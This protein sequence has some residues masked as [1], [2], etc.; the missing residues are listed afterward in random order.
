MTRSRLFKQASQCHLPLGLMRGRVSR[1]PARL[2][3]P[4]PQGLIPPREATGDSLRLTPALLTMANG[5]A[6]SAQRAKISIVIAAAI[7]ARDDVVDDQPGA[8]TTPWGQTLRCRAL[9]A[10]PPLDTLASFFPITARVVLVR[11]V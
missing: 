1:A 5:I 6:T 3:H 2:S 9:I 4:N 8:S 11:G 7:L 10:V